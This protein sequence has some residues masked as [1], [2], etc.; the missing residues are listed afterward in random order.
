MAVKE[1]TDTEIIDCLRKRQSY[2]VHY[3]SDR[4]LPVLRLMVINK[5]G[6]AEDAKDIFQEG[7]MIMLE[8]IDDRKFSLTCKFRTYLFC[9]CEKLWQLALAKR[10]I[11]E[12]YFTRKVDDDDEKDIHDIIDR[13]LREDLFRISFESLDEVSKK[14][15]KL[16]WQELSPQQIADKL[17]YTNGYV[18]RKKCE[19]QAALIEKVKTH[20]DY[21]KIRG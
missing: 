12:N 5:G 4:Y 15:L 6:T 9:V 19:A 21:E 7:L 13:S 18:R 3:L 2:V 10:Q 20:K 14:I 11:S 8:K 1:Y 16:Y 17:G